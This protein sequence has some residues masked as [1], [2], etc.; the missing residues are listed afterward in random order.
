MFM[1]FRSLWYERIARAWSARSIIWLSGV[2]RVGK[3]T[4]AKM[5]DLDEPVYRNC[6]LPSVVRELNDPEFFFNSVG[7]DTVVILDEIHQLADP[8]RLLKI[9]AD[10]YPNTKILATGS[11][12][13]AA[14]R[15]FRDALTGRKQSIHLSPVLWEE[16]K[17]TFK[18]TDFDRR[19]LRGGLP[20]ALLAT[21][22]PHDFYSEWF[23]SYYARDIA[24]LFQLRNRTAFLTLFHL[25][26]HQSG[27]QLD[28]SRL[29]KETELSRPTVV[30]Y[31]EALS[32][33]HAIQLV[34][35]FHGGSRREILRRPKCYAFDTGFVA[36]ERGWD[37]IRESDRGVLWEHLVLDSLRFKYSPDQVM[38][39][40]DKSGREIDFVIPRSGQ[41]IDTVECKMNPD[42]ANLDSI[43]AFRAVYPQ[44]KNYV[45]TP[46]V[47]NSY[48]YSRGE[49]VIDVTPFHLI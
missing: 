28:Y 31:V 49:L 19:L 15:K 27:G 46:F 22:Y 2:R 39:W 5:I 25:L 43:R 17:N 9:G 23:D 24:E 6:D 11:S 29:S 4:L 41:A 21:E 47:T 45:V 40:R 48:R 34:S 12:T 36:W 33:S 1:Y 30:S 44:G 3:T 13:L 14:T 38:Y 10:E 32:I 37:S 18:I 42:K 7:D 8:S 20:E 16:C 35:P 26:L